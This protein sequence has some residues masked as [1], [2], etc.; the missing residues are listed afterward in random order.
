MHGA[1]DNI[2]QNKPVLIEKIYVEA[3]YV[4]PLPQRAPKKSGLCQ[5][6]GNGECS[7][8]KFY[9]NEGY[10]KTKWFQLTTGTFRVVFLQLLEL[11]FLVKSGSSDGLYS[12][13][14]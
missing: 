14:Q 13:I 12:D 7:H 6:P 2:Q 3:Q 10:V 11:H 4:A 8:R 1:C 9:W 5:A